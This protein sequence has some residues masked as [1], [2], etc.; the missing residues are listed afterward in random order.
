MWGASKTGPLSNAKIRTALALAIDRA[1][2]AKV[3]FNGTARPA[4]A[5]S[6]T[7]TWESDPA[8]PIYRQGYDALN[9]LDQNLDEARK[10][11]NDN[12]SVVQPFIVAV[13]A[14]DKVA[15]QSATAIQAAAKDV[16][17]DMQIKQ[18]SAIDYSNLFYLDN[19]RNGIDGI[20]TVGYVENADPF[21]RTQLIIPPDG[22]FNWIGYDNPKAVD[23]LARGK[24]TLDAN[25]RAKLYIEAQ[26]V[27]MADMPNIPILDILARTYINKR[28]TG[29]VTSF[30][31]MQMPWAATLGAPE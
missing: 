4:W 6:P 30:A 9:H 16:G 7:A 12:K 26:Q 5:V 19:A 8:A 20:L 11:V 22:L 2:L 10:L 1:S 29:T 14:D 15:A 3:A 24:A 21:N 31:Y 28:V 27:F 23:L 17:L 18:F 25:E 13:L